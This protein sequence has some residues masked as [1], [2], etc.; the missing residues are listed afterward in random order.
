MGFR[1]SE[2]G[3]HKLRKSKGTEKRKKERKK[4]NKENGYWEQK[5]R[6]KQNGKFTPAEKLRSQITQADVNQSEF[7]KWVQPE[8]STPLPLPL[9][10]PPHSAWFSS[11]MALKARLAESI[12][13][14]LTC[15]GPRQTGILTGLRNVHVC[16]IL[17]TC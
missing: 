11:A 17:E 8:R 6:G 15:D 7:L 16:C 2:R 9:P 12:V 4:D 14:M 3:G 5:E 13:N 10:L 1:T